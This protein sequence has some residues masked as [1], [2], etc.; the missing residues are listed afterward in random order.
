M[1]FKQQN[2]EEFKVPHKHSGQRAD[3]AFSLLLSGVSRSQ[4]RRLIG[5][6]NILVEGKAI[7]PSRKLEGGELVSVVIPPPEP[8]E[9]LPQNIPISIIYEDEE[10]IVVD[11][12][13]GIVVHPGA[14]TKDGTLVNALLYMCRDLSGIGGKIRPGIVH[15][16]DKHTS[17]A[18][19]VAKSDF[20]HRNLVGQFKSRKVEKKYIAITA[21]VI[22]KSSGSFS[23][24]IGRH[25]T[26]RIKMTSKINIGREAITYW[27]VLKRYNEA[28]MVEVMPKT[29]RTHQ[30]RV[31]FAEGGFPILGDKIYGFRKQRSLFMESVSERLG[32][33]ALHASSIR[34]EHPK[35]GKQVEFN[36]PLSGDLRGVVKLLEE[37]SKR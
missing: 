1:V 12:P 17:G 20:A 27:R 13:P 15:R 10:I 2:L 23:S 28:T 22:K 3:V 16:L 24:P 26:N 36:A 4:V 35:T 7:K 34:F 25:P 32:R 29:G 37:K 14:G 30:I 21:G 31:H 18:L 5:E 11:K 33:Q 19:V 9:L 6:K 8:L